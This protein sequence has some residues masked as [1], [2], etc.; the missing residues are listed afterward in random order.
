[1]FSGIVEATSPIISSSPGDKTLQ[2]EVLRPSQFNDLSIG[3]SVAVNGICLTVESFNHSNILFTLGNE[4]LQILG[5]SLSQWLQ[6]PVNL[7]RSLRFGDRVHGHFVS[8]HVDTIVQ[9]LSSKKLGDNW[10][11]SIKVPPAFSAYCWVKGSVALNGVSLTIN[12]IS[13]YNDFNHYAET[14]KSEKSQK[15]T[16]KQLEVCLIPET[17]KRTNL[18]LFQAEEKLTFEVDSFAKAVVHVIEQQKQALEEAADP[19][20]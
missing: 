3:D 7:E 12:K 1:M 20:D 13:N 8:G 19:R 16:A 4:T 10:I 9:V 15:Q 11:L 5:E 6:K 17:Q 2:I 14:E 18:P